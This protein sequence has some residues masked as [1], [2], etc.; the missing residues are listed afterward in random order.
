MKTRLRARLLLAAIVGAAMGVA[1]V[2]EASSTDAAFSPARMSSL[3]SQPTPPPPEEEELPEAENREALRSSKSGGEINV[4]RFLSKVTQDADRVWVDYFAQTPGLE[5]PFVTY[6]LV[7]TTQ[8]PTYTLSRACGGATIDTDHKNAYYCST[9]EGDIVLPV[10]TFA[11]IWQGDFFG[12][13]PKNTG[14]FAA[15][16]VVV[17]EFGHHIQDEILKQY[18]ER[19]V[20]VPNY[21]RNDKNKELI[22]DC[23]A[24]TWAFSAYYKGFVEP[25]DYDEAIDSVRAIGDPPG[26]ASHGTPDERQAAFEEGYNTGEPTRCIIRYWPGAAAALGL[27]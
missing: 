8:E 4:P 12:R 6:H 7:G 24:G 3:P 9:G 1:P 27:S 25:G 19:G 21:K 13:A 5:E 22:A 17:H 16:F 14:D 23:F 10:N 20:P 15:A 11:R 26:V 18:N 2:A